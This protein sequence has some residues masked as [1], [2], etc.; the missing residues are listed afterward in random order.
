MSD[1]EESSMRVENENEATGGSAVLD[2]AVL[3]R[4]RAEEERLLI[5]KSGPLTVWS[6]AISFF[7]SSCF[8]SEWL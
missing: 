5:Y 2:L 8:A 6:V 1:G 7:P 4:G 3:R